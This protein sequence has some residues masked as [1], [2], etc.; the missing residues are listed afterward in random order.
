MRRLDDDQL[1]DARE[2]V[3]DC[4]GCWRDLD[5][6]EDVDALPAEQIEAGIDRHYAGGIAQFKADGAEPDRGAP[7]DAPTLFWPRPYRGG[8]CNGCG[9][10]LL[11]NQPHLAGCSLRGWTSIDTST[12]DTGH[13]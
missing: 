11:R 4:L 1:R 8:I 3:K 9:A 2:W 5:D 7:P 12:E 13:A 6:V 10:D